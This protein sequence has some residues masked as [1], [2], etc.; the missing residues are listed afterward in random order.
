MDQ[1]FL[2]VGCPFYCPT[3]SIK[4]KRKFHLTSVIQIWWIDSMSHSLKRATWMQP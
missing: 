2:L 3:I 4:A 1:D